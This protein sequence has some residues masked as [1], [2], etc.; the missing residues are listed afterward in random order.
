[1]KQVLLFSVVAAVSLISC[2]KNTIETPAPVRATGE[3][4][5][6]LQF[7]NQNDL[8]KFAHYNEDSI[9]EMRATIGEGKLWLIF[10]AA[11]TRNNS[12]GDAIAF[13]IDA[14]HVGSGLVG[15]YDYVNTNFRIVSTRYTYTFKNNDGDINGSILDLSMGVHYTGIL[16]I[17]KYDVSRKLV[18]GTYDIYAKDLIN[19]PTKH[20]PTSPIDP[21]DYCHLHIEGNFTNVKIE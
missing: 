4:S 17:L 12:S 8:V 19:D 1:M 2:K 21:A 15:S 14:S 9:H 11:P 13:T 7:P 18:S 3:F 16:T 6:S 5:R 10:N 20:T